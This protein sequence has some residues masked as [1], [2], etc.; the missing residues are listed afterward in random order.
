MTILLTIVLQLFFVGFI[1][2]I[3]AKSQKTKRYNMIM[4]WTFTLITIIPTY[5]LSCYLISCP[6]IGDGII[7]VGAADAYDAIV[8]NI[9]L[10]LLPL[11]FMLIYWIFLCD[12][13]TKTNHISLTLLYFAFVV[14]VLL[15]D[16][17]IIRSIFG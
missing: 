7:R 15:W 6:W 14:T 5:Q 13:G 2:T 17:Q 16:S 9:C 8:R 10:P 1:S 3:N 12:I 4:M 11:T